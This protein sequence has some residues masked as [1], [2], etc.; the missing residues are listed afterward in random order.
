MNTKTTIYLIGIF[1][2]LLLGSNSLYI[3]KEPEKAVMLRFR[4]LIIDDIPPG[5][6]IKAPLIDTLLKFDGRILTLDARPERF[7]TSEKKAV[8]VDSYVKWR[9]SNVVTYYTAT[10]GEET[11]AQRLLAQRINEG[12]R[13]QFGERTLQEVV[14]GERDLLMTEIRTSLNIVTEKE[15]GVTLVDIRVKKID[16]PNQV[17]GNVHSRMN[18]EREREARR[19][20]SEG[21]EKAELTK[22]NADREKT[23]IT[24][25]AYRDSEKIRGLGDAKAA[26]IYAKAYNKDPE[27]YSFVRSLEAYKNTFNDKSDLMIVDPDNDFFKYLNKSRPSK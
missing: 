15:M 23:I 22:A 17:S 5:L 27:F 9:I 11:R 3:I 21:K 7:L 18:S 10:S 16:L 25:N 6:H 12:L 14:A 26:A 24:A 1:F 19:H 4:K 8:I 13:N 2:L 20:R